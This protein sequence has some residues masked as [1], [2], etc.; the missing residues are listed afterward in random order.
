MHVFPQQS[1]HSESLSAQV[2]QRL[3]WASHYEQKTHFNFCL[4]SYGFTVQLWEN[5]YA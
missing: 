3:L 1:I 2:T 4:M 5:G